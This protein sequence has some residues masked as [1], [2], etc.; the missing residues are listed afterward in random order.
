M[1]SYYSNP[2]ASAAIGAVDREISLMKK[3]AKR[4]KARRRMGLL[5][6]QEIVRARREFTGIYRRFL[7][8]AL[9]E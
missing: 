5:T 6:P 1:S 8:E 2:T 7:R 4:I 9:A 3:K